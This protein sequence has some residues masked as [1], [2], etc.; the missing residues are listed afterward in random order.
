MITEKDLNKA[1]DE[2]KDTA[3][4]Y[5]NCE[6]L[7]TFLTIR[8]HLYG[9]KREE[10]VIRE[11]EIVSNHGDSKFLTAI[12]GKDAEAMWQVMDEMMDAIA[13]ANPRLH[14]A[15]YRKIAE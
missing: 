5:T 1:I 12:T 11:E 8:D 4:S 15:I 7:A 6:K 2:C 10:A 9:S 14:E 13:V 3:T